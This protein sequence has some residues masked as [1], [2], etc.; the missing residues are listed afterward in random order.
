M[1]TTAPMTIRL[2]SVSVAAAG[3]AFVGPV[4][5]LALYFNQRAEMNWASFVDIAVPQMGRAAMWACMS[6][7][8]LMLR[9]RMPLNSGHWFGGLVF[10][11]TF[12]FIIMATF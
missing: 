8:I 5:S 7:F 4:S 1:R 12:S 11:I 10:H 6:P 2:Q 3:C 9:A